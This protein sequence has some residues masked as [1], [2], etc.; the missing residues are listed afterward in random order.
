MVL[1]ALAAVGLVGNVVQFIDFSCQL[2]A[3]TMVVHH[4]HAGA[5]QHIRD[6]E[7][8][9]KELQQWCRIIASRRNSQGQLLPSHNNRSLVALVA[10]C[11][12][13]AVELLSALH[14]LKA[15]DTE[16]RWSC[17]RAALAVTW[18]ESQINDMERRLDTY[19]QQILLELSYMQ[20]YYN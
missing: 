2:F 8:I 17:F 3:T 18:N 4:S 10:G 6:I 11:E 5:P 7:S 12:N 13:A 16:S 20:R 14:A 19:R 15:K 9:T 1:E